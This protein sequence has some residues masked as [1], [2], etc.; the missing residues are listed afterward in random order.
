MTTQH[1]TPPIRK[2]TR[3]GFWIVLAA[4]LVCTFL[5]AAWLKQAGSP[6]MSG[7][8]AGSTAPPLQAAGWIGGNPPEQTPREGNLRLVHAWFTTCPACHRQAAELVKLH[9]QYA[10][11]GVE[12]VGLTYEPAERL[13]E[14]R[15][16]LEETGMTWVNGYGALETLQQFD[17]EYF[18]SIWLIDS[19]GRILWS[20]D[21]PEPL[22]KAIPLA[23]AG[24][25][26]AKRA[27]SP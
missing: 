15:K 21:S 14:I 17:V 20:L 24:K 23:L 16:T 7:L 19:E 3:R 9:E 11:R 4:V 6:Q 2:G 12:F 26:D 8:S 27:D 10:D 13:P 25:L 5:M 22:E 1:P 18:P